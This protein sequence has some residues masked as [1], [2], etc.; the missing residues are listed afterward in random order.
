MNNDFYIQ[1]EKTKKE[2][3][4][5]KKKVVLNQKEKLGGNGQSTLFDLWKK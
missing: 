5:I 4:S 2:K 3:G 1:N